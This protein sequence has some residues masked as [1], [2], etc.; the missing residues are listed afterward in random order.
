MARSRLLEPTQTRREVDPR[1][2]DQ[3]IARGVD[4]E[5]FVSGNELLPVSSLLE[6]VSTKQISL[7]T[8]DIQTQV[9]RCKQGKYGGGPEESHYYG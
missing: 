7:L 9:I 4:F 1:G 2:E 6:A 5:Q 8:T 3:S